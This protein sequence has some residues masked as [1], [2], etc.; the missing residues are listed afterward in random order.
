[1][2]QIITGFGYPAPTIKLPFLLIYII[3]FLLH[4]VCLALKPIKHIQ[5]TFTPMT[6]SLAGTHHFYS[7]QKAKEDLKYVPVVKMEQAVTQ[8]IASFPHLKNA[9]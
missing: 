9:N 8:T 2:T 6:V 4:L 3:A 1:M 5:P 7:C